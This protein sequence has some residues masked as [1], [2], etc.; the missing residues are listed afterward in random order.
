MILSSSSPD[1]V[2]VNSKCLQGHIKLNLYLR[3]RRSG[4]G[5][6]SIIATYHHHP[7]RKLFSGHFLPVCK[8]MGPVCV[9]VNSQCLLGHIKLN[10]YLSQEVRRSNTLGPRPIQGPGPR[11][12]PKIF[13][14][15]LD[16]D[17]DQ[18]GLWQLIAS[19][20]PPY[21]FHLKLQICLK[22]NLQ[23]VQD[24][25]EHFLILWT[26]IWTKTLTKTKTR[27]NNLS[28]GLDSNSSLIMMEL[29]AADLHLV[30]GTVF[31]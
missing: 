20:H 24:I 5:A 22:D 10:L 18:E 29:D 28:L 1:P 23:N 15:V 30:Y 3:I 12:R 25:S 4:H 27:T 21:N 8:G 14:T 11:P 9:E 7:P 2:H 16:Q 13:L 31:V 17:Q 19:Y 26:K 6:D